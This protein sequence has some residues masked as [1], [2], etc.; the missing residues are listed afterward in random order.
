MK[1]ITLITF[2]IFSINLFSQVGIKGGVTYSG[3]S[4][5][6]DPS[7]SIGTSF[8]VFTYLE[9]F[10]PEI[11]FYQQTYATTLSSSTTNY[12]NLSANYAVNITDAI[13]FVGGLGWDYWISSSI[14][15]NGTTTKISSSGNALDNLMWNLNLGFAYNISD[16][17]IMD[18]RY[19]KPFANGLLED[20]EFNSSIYGTLLTVGY[21][22]GN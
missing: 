20:V 13:S 16:V 18:I 21:I 3:L 1:K 19:T 10:R 9:S 12:L 4:N 7:I 2:C 14:K 8:G 15:I 5:L 17:L 22:F 6:T 11:N